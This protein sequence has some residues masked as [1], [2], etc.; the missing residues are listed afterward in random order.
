MTVTSLNNEYLSGWVKTK[1]EFELLLNTCEKAT[2]SNFVSRYVTRCVIYTFLYT[3]YIILILYY[4]TFI[5]YFVYF[6]NNRP[7]EK[8]I[9]HN[10][11]Q[12]I[13]LSLGKV[14]I[15]K[16]PFQLEQKN[17]YICCYK[18]ISPTMV[19]TTINYSILEILQASGGLCASNL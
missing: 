13:Y 10:K 9:R 14:P 8:A 2:M 1:I 11:R 16:H 6:S 15:N 3:L 12:R 4:Y 7:A 19:C 17:I 18:E 5:I